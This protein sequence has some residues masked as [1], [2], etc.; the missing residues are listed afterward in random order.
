VAR[1]L[2]LQG[3]NL[4][5]HGYGL[6]QVYLRTTEALETF[7]RPVALVTIVL[8]DE[9]ERSAVGNR[10]HL[11]LS[12]DGSLLLQD[13]AP[14]L[15]QTSPL[16]D[17]LHRAAHYEDGDAIDV[18][19]TILRSTAAR[20]RAHGALPLFVMTNF[21]PPCLPDASGDPAL[22]HVL[23]DDLAA[24]HLRVDL[25]PAWRLTDDPHPDARASRKLADAIEQALRRE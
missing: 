20:A 24:P 5:V 11:A 15:W 13:P 18:A 17:L 10:K 12:R 6:D 3:A 23:F 22:E 1:E 14:S 9:L 4:G 16:R 7:A 19:R 2:G 25:D 8:A 21:G